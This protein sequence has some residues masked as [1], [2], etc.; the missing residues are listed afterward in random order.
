[1]YIIKVY[2]FAYKF[3]NKGYFYGGISLKLIQVGASGK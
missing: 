3:L 2:V 1:M